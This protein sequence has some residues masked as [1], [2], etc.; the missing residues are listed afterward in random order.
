MVEE[1]QIDKLN[2]CHREKCIEYSPET[3]SGVRTARRP[4]R[5]SAN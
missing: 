4:E 5:E 1:A 2:I 3:E